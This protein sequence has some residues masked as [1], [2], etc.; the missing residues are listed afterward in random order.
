MTPPSEFAVVI[1]D[2][3]T[4][5]AQRVAV[6]LVNGLSAQGRTVTLITL[7]G[8]ASDRFSTDS[9]VRRI[10]LDLVRPTH[11]IAAALLDNIRR[12]WRL[13]AA[14]RQSGAPVVVALV[15]I[16]N[17]LTVLA[18]IGLPV[19]VVISER[20]DPTQQSLGRPWDSLR[21]R[22]YRHAAT[23]TANSATALTAMAA[24]VPKAKLALVPNAV[25]A[26]PPVIRPPHSQ[27]RVLAVGRLSRQKAHDVLLHAFALLPASCAAWR[28]C[29]VG[30]GEE[31]ESLV[32]IAEQHGI[33]ERVEWRSATPEAIWDFYRDADVFVLASRHEGTPNALLEAMACG[34]PPIV[35]AASAGALDCIKPGESGLVV[36]VQDPAALAA[37]LEALM[38]DPALRDR[39]GRAAR[40]Q[41][42]ATRPTSTVAVW[43]PV[44]GIP[45][46]PSA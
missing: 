23:V 32:R 41:V 38:T 26:P 6:S 20:N 22:L 10:A 29:I 46:T 11:G 44:L 14:V 25:E 9:R 31:Q 35:S 42:Q 7:A 40:L 13:R 28:L 1:A 34:L 2:L 33:G 18:C 24:Y 45:A 21:R 12:L 16:T 27:L 8:T 39:M 3:G 19:R 5:G 43:G 15:G 37:A 36:P 17:I 30:T 4:G